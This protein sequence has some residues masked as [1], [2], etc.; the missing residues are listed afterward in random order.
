MRKSQGFTLVELILTIAIGTIVT[1]SAAT[2][3]LLGL[4]VN[5]QG[6][7]I[8][9][10]QY[11]ARIILTMLEDLA[12][13]GAIKK[14]NPGTAGW[15]I[16]GEGD[17]LLL[18]Y[19]AEAQKIKSGETTILD[20]VYA[21]HLSVD[22]SGRVLTFAIETPEGSYTTSVY[23]RTM[24]YTK[25]GSVDDAY[26]DEADQI[27]DGPVDTTGARKAFLE[28]LASQYQYADGTPNA[29]M[30]IDDGRGTGEFYSQWYVGGEYKGNW[31]RNTPWCACFV[32]WALNEMG[33]QLKAPADRLAEDVKGDDYYKWYA[34]VDEFMEYFQKKTDGAKWIEPEYYLS[35]DE[36]EEKPHLQPGDLV[37]FDWNEDENTEHVGVVIKIAAGNIYTIEGNSAGIVAVRQYALSD[38]RI[39]GYGVLPW[40]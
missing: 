37:F 12:G 28:I 18:S 15:S 5:S 40:A 4:R 13:E 32:S 23:C 10:N 2:V 35:E 3:L 21:S 19:V 31:N 25:E 9:H 34:N 8:V 1:F 27:L 6:T 33:N 24:Q 39:L 11:T 30:I 38:S 36:L 17:T 14:V 26:K 7:E 29:G 16:T 20:D 22:H